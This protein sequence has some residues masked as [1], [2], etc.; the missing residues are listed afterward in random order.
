MKPNLKL[1]M[2]ICDVISKYPDQFNMRAWECGT[3]ACIAGWA[4]RLNGKRHGSF[5]GTSTS[6][7]EAAELLGINHEQGELLFLSTGIGGDTKKAINHIHLCLNRWYPNW[8]EELR[9]EVGSVQL[10]NT[11]RD[12]SS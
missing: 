10:L 9:K 2:A 6:S 8:R 11:T 3:S 5:D 12:K 1:F 7:A 4:L